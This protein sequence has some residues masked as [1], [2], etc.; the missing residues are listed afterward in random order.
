MIFKF[1]EGE[2]VA[3]KEDY[4]DALPKG[5]QGVVFCL[6]HT[7]PP[8][9]EVIL[10]TVEGREYGAIMDEQ[11]LVTVPQKADACPSPTATAAA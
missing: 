1:K 9:Y 4:T 8:A 7:T 2:R 10:L 3:L 5:S 11:D 6:Y